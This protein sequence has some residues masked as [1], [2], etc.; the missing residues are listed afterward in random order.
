MCAIFGL[1]DYKK[2]FSSAQRSL[3]INV[4]AEECEVR[5]TD[6]TGFAFN[7]DGNLKIF[8]RP[9]AAHEINLR[10]HDDANVILGHT[11]MATQGD[12]RY[13][14]NNHPFYGNANDTKFALAHNGIVYNDHE[15]AVEMGL[16]KTHIK[17]DSYVAVQLIEQLG[18]LN[19]RSLAE[20]AERISGPF[21]FTVLDEN[22]NSYFV[23]GENPLALYHFKDGFY[24]YASTDVILETALDILGLDKLSHREV[25][26]TCGDILKIDSKGRITRSHFDPLVEVSRYWYSPRSF[27]GCAFPDLYDVPDEYIELMIDYG[28]T[29]EDIEDLC[30]IPEAIETAVSEILCEQGY[31]DE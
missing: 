4:L 14:Y 24:I 17:T 1:I 13:N 30:G 26:T 27:Y 22:N 11:R 21:V 9:Y 15:I 23:K 29:L 2:V 16:P 8:K 25:V 31:F 12:K 3:I 5:G 6:A 19:E 18:E 10:L 28:Y 7:S 20:M